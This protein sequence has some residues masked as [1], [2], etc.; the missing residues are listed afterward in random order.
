MYSKFAE[1]MAAKVK[2]NSSELG[3]YRGMLHPKLGIQKIPL[4]PRILTEAQKQAIEAEK[5]A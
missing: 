2:I 3:K 4:F 5:E 1:D